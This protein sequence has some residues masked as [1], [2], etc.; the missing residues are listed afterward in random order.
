MSRK[1]LLVD[2]DVN[3]LGAL[4]ADLATRSRPE[5]AASWD[6]LLTDCAQPWQLDEAAE[7]DLL[8]DSAALAELREP[9][10]D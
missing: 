1:V 8:F 6:Q 3:A 4:A 2:A 7:L 9:V 10:R 5:A